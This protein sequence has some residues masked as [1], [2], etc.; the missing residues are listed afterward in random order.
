MVGNVAVNRFGTIS[1]D[2]LLLGIEDPSV[3]VGP[4]ATIALA[5]D[6]TLSRSSPILLPVLRLLCGR[7]DAERPQTE[8]PVQ[9]H[10]KNLCT[11]HRDSV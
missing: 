7:C 6:P 4:G 8:Y 3:I 9:T 10:C 1:A 2:R 11:A 5:P